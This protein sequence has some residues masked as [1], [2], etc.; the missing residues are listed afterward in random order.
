M[1]FEWDENK[2][3]TNLKKH[4]IS[5]QEATTVF[6]D[7]MALTF[8]DPDHSF[9]ECRLLTF[10][11]TKAGELVVSHVELEEDRIRLI[12]ARRMTKQEQRVYREG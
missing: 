9:G 11:K 1:I 10:G 6:S 7:P 3:R 4:G 5:F 2:A 8:D 12:S